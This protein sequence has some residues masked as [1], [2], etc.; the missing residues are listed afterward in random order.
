MLS[1]HEKVRRKRNRFPCHHEG[2]GVGGDDRDNQLERADWRSDGA[3]ERRRAKARVL[4]PW[5]QRSG[6][7]ASLDEQ[8]ESLRYVSASCDDSH[9]PSIPA[10]RGP[11]PGA[12]VTSRKRGSFI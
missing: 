4:P 10:T 5:G 1:R 8:T 12:R 7:S 2:I 11:S 3:H 9:F 6:A